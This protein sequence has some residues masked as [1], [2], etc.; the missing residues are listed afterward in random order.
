M[1]TAH[2]NGVHANGVHANGH[3]NGAHA[4]ESARKNANGNALES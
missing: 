4:N 2:A 1:R 3:A